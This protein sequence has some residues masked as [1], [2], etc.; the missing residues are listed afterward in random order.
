MNEALLLGG[1]SVLL[2][3]Y[4]RWG[5][6]VLPREGWQIIAALPSGKS[7]PHHWQGTNLTW[8]GILTA[9][10]YLVAV[11]VF[12]A[13]MGARGI[14]A[15]TSLLLALAL[16]CIC[17]PAS[18]LV[19]RVVEK[20]KHTFT[21]GGAVFV[22]ILAAPPLVWFYNR[23]AAEAGATTIPVMAACAAMATAYCFGEGLGRLACISFGC[24]Y[25]KPLSACS[26]WLRRLF[27]GRCF[28]FFGDTR[29]IAYAGGLE[30]TEV[31]PVQAL[32]AILFNVCGLACGA[33]F[34]AGHFRAS[35]LTAILTT[36]LWRSLSENLRA[37][38]RGEGSLSAYQIMGMLASVY[39]LVTALIMGDDGGA[40]PHLLRGLALLW[41]PRQILFLQCVWLVIF[42]YTGRSTVTGSTISFHVHRDRI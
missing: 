31:I 29:K 36:Q 13:L 40:L 42:V 21:V 34:L 26:G 38:Y 37:D 25:G 22:G 23:A 32:T 39:A 7:G 17:V 11:T 35:F 27:S 5:F 10:A 20:K 9:N 12:L 4:L 18:R 41:S 1:V 30:A 3:V 33:L 8:Y 28:V 24:C 16:L 19:A 6:A 2:V 14:P 15:G